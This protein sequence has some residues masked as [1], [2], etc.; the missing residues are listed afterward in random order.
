MEKMIARKYDF[1]YLFNNMFH[2]F[3]GVSWLGRQLPIGQFFV[4]KQGSSW[5]AGS[6]R[7]GDI[8]LLAS[9]I[10]MES[11]SEEISSSMLY[12]SR[13]FSWENGGILASLAKFSFNIFRWINRHIM[14]KWSHAHIVQSYPVWV[15]ANIFISPKL[16][17]CSFISC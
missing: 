11:S 9:M 16:N 8:L 7:R 12:I 10:L 13:T 4:C 6:W 5:W 14:L 15:Y 3:G 2:R 1:F 17:K